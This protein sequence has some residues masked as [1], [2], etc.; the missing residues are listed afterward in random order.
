MLASLITVLLAEEPGSLFPEREKIDVVRSVRGP[1]SWDLEWS[2]AE[3]RMRGAVRPLDPVSGRPLEL[4]VLVGTFQGAEF[5]GP[6]TVTMRCNAWSDT[7][8]VRRAKGEKAWAAK[9][10]PV[11]DGEDCSIDLSF[12]TTRHKL[13]H[14]KVP[15]QTAP[16]SRWPWFVLLG[17]G[18][19]I[20]LGLG[21]RS[22]F[23]KP[24]TA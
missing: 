22:L 1:T 7:Q 16:L 12:T 14:A 21:I 18:T 13:L 24:E 2:D 20:A 15:V 8:T 23:K 9:F 3:D 5:D 19:A 11:A 17:L 6:V 4:S 10:V